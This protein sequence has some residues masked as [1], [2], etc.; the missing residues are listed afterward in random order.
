MEEH[1]T[2]VEVESA[3]S[4]VGRVKPEKRG[5]LM[6]QGCIV[7][8]LALVLVG[9]SVVAGM[10]GLYILQEKGVIGSKSAKDA[11]V[12]YVLDRRQ[13]CELAFEQTG[14]ICDTDYECKWKVELP[15]FHDV[16]MGKATVKVKGVYLVKFG[17]NPDE[18]KLWEFYPGTS[19]L[20]ASIPPVKLLSIQT[21]AQ[22]ICAEDESW[23][24]K[25]QKE[26]RNEALQKNREQAEVKARQM[27]QDDPGIRQACMEQL[28]KLLSSVGVKLVLV[29]ETPPLL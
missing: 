29:Q 13:I 1:D 15:L 26:D 17:I 14:L 27:L 16:E 12:S 23:L 25:L 8:I 6:K 28:K 22:E 21:E 3:H 20:H 2:P 19:E 7:A 4:P 24:K 11:G 18:V 5:G 10:L 9:V